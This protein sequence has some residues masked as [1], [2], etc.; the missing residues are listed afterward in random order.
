MT[1]ASA[2]GRRQRRL[3][4]REDRERQAAA[5]RKRAQRRR[6]LN[7]GAL[8]VLALAVVA[9]GGF[10]LFKTVAAPLP[11]RSVPDEGRTHVDQ[12]T[13]VNYKNDPPASGS[14]YP[15]WIRAGVYSEPLEKGNWVHS[16]EHG[17]VVILYNC[18]AGCP[19]LQDQLRQFYESAPKSSRYNYQKL[20]IAPYPT[21]THQI[22]AVA[23]DH[24][25]D[26]DQFDEGQLM[27]FYKGY[28]DHGPEDAP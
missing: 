22:A 25:F 14:H 20:V 2:E 9:G 10:L 27:G 21:L 11:G 19:Q 1:D 7:V 24:I 26:L 4:A 5:G 15:T 3:A 13:P 17:Y 6:R 12:G 18:P 8:L 16:L 23:W 28:L